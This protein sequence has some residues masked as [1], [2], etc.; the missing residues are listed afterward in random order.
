[1]NSKRCYRDKLDRDV[2]ISE[3]EKN[4]GVQFDP[5]ITDIFLGIIES[6][7]IQL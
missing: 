4:R 7:E 3:L 5:D 1:M 2:I 6:G